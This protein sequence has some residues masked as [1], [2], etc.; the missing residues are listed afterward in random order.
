MPR[1]RYEVAVTLI[2][3]G[4]LLALAPPL[5]DYLAMRQIASIIVEREDFNRVSMG[6]EPMSETYRAGLWTLAAAMIGIAVAGS[7]AG[8]K[9]PWH[10]LDADEAS[11]PSSLPTPSG[12]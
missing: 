6:I 1:L 11:D 5:S 10:E 7:L 4:T 8:S 12:A 9:S 3:C 2:G